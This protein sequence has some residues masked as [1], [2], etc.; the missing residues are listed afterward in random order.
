MA[1]IAGR[2][3]MYKKGERKYLTQK[4]PL[5]ERKPSYYFSEKASSYLKYIRVVRKYIQ[6]KYELSI[7]ELELVLYLYDETIFDNKT[8]VDYSS[9]LGFS[10]IDWL[11]R[12]KERGIVKKWRDEPGYKRLY[13][14]THKYK[15]ACNKL[16]KHL[17]GEPIPTHVNQN[18]LFKSTASYS[19]KM[20]ARL[21]KQMNKKREEGN[22]SDLSES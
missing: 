19:D 7:S 20:Y 6:K 5:V 17:E 11:H 9:I 10:T 16:Y 13:T 15:I 12:L 4:R 14:L 18:P 1:R 21:I 22:K 3:R 2:R 8:F